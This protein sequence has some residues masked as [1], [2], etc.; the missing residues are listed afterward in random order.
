[1]LYLQTEF[2]L[3]DHCNDLWNI[4]CFIILLQ[5]QET[6]GWCLNIWLSVCRTGGNLTC[7]LLG[8]G[9]RVT[10]AWVSSPRASADWRTDAGRSSR[11]PQSSTPRWPAGGGRAASVATATEGRRPRRRSLRQPDPTGRRPPEDGAERH[12]EETDS[13]NEMMRSEQKMWLKFVFV[14]LWSDD[15]RLTEKAFFSHL[16]SFLRAQKEKMVNISISTTLMGNSAKTQHMLGERLFQAQ[17][18]CK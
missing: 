13:L 1:M 16:W 12:W 17:K 10:A 5:L 6:S 2:S 18:G 15:F 11:R 8:T 7:E 14:L 4:F 3:V 9:R